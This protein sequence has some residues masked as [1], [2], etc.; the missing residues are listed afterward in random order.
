MNGNNSLFVSVIIPCRNEEKFIAKCLDTIIEQD[1]PKE[2]LEV[3]AIDGMS[4]DRTW[5]IIEKFTLKYPFIKLLENPQKYTSFGLNKGIKEARGE[6]IIR[7]DAHAGYEKDYIS[8]CVKYSKEYNADNIGGIIK[9]LPAKD[10]IIAKAIAMVLSHPF[11]AGGS[12]FRIGAKTPKWVDT[13]FGGCYKK[14]IFDKIGLFNE[15]LIRSQDLEFNLR[16]KKVGGKIL[17]VPD[18]VGYYYPET[19]LSAFLKKNFR[20]GIWAI[21]PFKFTKTPLRLRHYI[22]ALFTGFLILSGLLSFVY[23]NFF[24]LLSLSLFFYLIV[25]F[26]FAFRVAVQERDIRYLFLMPVAFACRHFGYGLGSIFGIIKL[27]KD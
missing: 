20:D 16:L 3:L 4:E 2:N 7:M 15:N 12:Y 6:V 23:L 19:T 27:I 8:K 21:Y 18:I 11:G 26:Y 14:E 22:P 25:S 10:T 24:Y 17:L 13:V 1:F 5:G 9:T